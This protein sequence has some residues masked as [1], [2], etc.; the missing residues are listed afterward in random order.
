MICLWI[1]L[2][3]SGSWKVAFDSFFLLSDFSNRLVVKGTLLLDSDDAPC[4]SM[5]GF[6]MEASFALAE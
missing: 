4:D 5:F 1:S 2:N 3:W 6:G